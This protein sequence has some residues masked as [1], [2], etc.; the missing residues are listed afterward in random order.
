MSD[1]HV[2]VDAGITNPKSKY[3]STNTE[4]RLLWLTLILLGIVHT[5]TVPAVK[6]LA[7]TYILSLL[8]LVFSFLVIKIGW[9]ILSC[10]EIVEHAICSIL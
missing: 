10:T 5:K 8:L 1:C 6:D 9:K 7:S 4:D 3:H 2:F